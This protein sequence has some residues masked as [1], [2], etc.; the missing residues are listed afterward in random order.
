MG[1]NKKKLIWKMGQNFL[2]MVNKNVPSGPEAKGEGGER[3]LAVFA[4][5]LTR[6]GS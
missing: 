5:A 6:D 4:F 1:G 2:Y 3:P